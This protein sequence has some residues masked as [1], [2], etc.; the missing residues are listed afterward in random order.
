[1]AE[2]KCPLDDKIALIT[3]AVNKRTRLKITYLKARDEKSAREIAPYEIGKIEY[4][5]MSFLGV[6][7]FCHKRR[8]DRVFRLDRILEIEQV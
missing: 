4:N 6:R 2:L 5:D 3:E 1:L 7:A 8:E